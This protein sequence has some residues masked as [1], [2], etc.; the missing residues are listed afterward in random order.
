LV[1]ETPDRF[2]FVQIPKKLQN[3]QI[4]LRQTVKE[5]YIDLQYSARYRKLTRTTQSKIVAYTAH[6]VC[7]VVAHTC[8]DIH[9][10]ARITFCGS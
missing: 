9:I 7:I 4:V 5:K 2:F 6:I 1:L 3:I 10:K 8:G